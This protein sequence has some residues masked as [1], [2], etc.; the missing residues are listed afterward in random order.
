MK[1][2][3]ALLTAIMMVALLVTAPAR[4]ADHG[5][6][7]CPVDACMAWTEALTKMANVAFKNLGLGVLK[8]T[9]QVAW[10]LDKAALHIFD[11]VVHGQIWENL[12]SG[13]LDSLASFMPDVLKDLIGGADGLLYIALMVAGVSMTI[14]FVK[15]RLVNPGQAILWAMVLLAV[16][17]PGAMGYD[18]IGAIEE[19]RVGMM[20]KIIS[21]GGESDFTS[22]ITGPMQASG[23][24]L[25]VN[26]QLPS[27]FEDEYF[28]EPQG[29]QTVRTVFMEGSIP[30]NFQAVTDVEVETDDS[31]ALRRERAIP[32]VFIALLSLVGGYAAFLFAL[33]FALLMTASLG[34]IIFLFAALPMGLFEFGRTVVAGIFDKYLQIVILSIGAS[35][36]AA[37][38][39]MTVSTIPT[40]AATI[41]DALKQVA[42]LM[43]I[44]GVEHMFV[45][46]AFE[47]MMDSRSVF[48]RSM[49][50]V[51]SSPGAAPAAGLRRGAASTLRTVGSAA[52]WAT[53]GFA[54][55]AAG[56]AA[57]VA[58]NA[59]GPGKAGGKKRGDVFREMRKGA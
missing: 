13:V 19:V 34:L 57:N 17:G 56:M 43:P 35:I 58:A 40:S 46:W 44:L 39:A 55:I 36:F 59:I 38:V 48:R 30:I 33:I 54:G 5:E 51:F 29:H 41:G 52:A 21:A 20:E 42:I 7:D 53:P 12:R 26:T 23:S 10:M 8:S 24:D 14:P 27:A 45:K 3:S 6:D 1:R 50:A 28:L 11:L 2:F 22:I 47:A 4:A 37:I 25:R 18:L 49:N 32:G 31:L 15:N 9:A 16:F